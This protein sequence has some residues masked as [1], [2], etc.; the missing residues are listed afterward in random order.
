MVL[1]WRN[2]TDVAIVIADAAGAA[3][4]SGIIIT[5]GAIVAIG[6][7]VGVPAIIS[8]VVFIRLPGMQETPYHRVLL[9]WLIIILLFRGGV[10]PFPG[11]IIVVIFIFQFPIEEEL[12][13]LAVS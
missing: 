9:G 6:S 13:V 4:V 1:D 11:N 5:T 7:I 2:R 12:E 10:V 8:I 3:I